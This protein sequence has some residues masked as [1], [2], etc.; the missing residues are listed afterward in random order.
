MK[1]SLNYLLE[2]FE[3][4]GF[5]DFFQSFVPSVKY[6]VLG[7]VLLWS[8][9]FAEIDRTFGIDAG[10]VMALALVMAFE[11]ISGIYASHIQ[12]VPFSSKKLSRFTF[13]CA[14]YLVLIAVPYLFEV[15]FKKHGN[16][17][18]GSL[19]EWLHIFFVVQIV[20]ENIVSILE[21]LSVIQGKDKTYWIDRIKEKLRV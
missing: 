12:H 6:N 19:F 17:I 4:N 13:K 2:G 9:C 16:S 8:A 1:K 20:L 5:V 10:A 7:L 11:L 18:A 21:N 15:S 14:C 3:Y